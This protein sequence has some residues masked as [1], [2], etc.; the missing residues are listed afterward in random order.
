LFNAFRKR[1]NA[2]EEQ[3]HDS[4]CNWNHEKV[5]LKKKSPFSPTSPTVS[6]KRDKIYEFVVT[7][8]SGSGH[9][10]NH[11]Q[12]GVILRNERAV[13]KFQSA[14]PKRDI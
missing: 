8:P 10:N 13:N 11:K 12:Q 6:I 14:V 3:I 2:S 4:T 5:K 7:D 9:E 1:E